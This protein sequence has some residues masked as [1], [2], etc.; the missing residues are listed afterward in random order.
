MRMSERKLEESYIQRG[1]LV[2][3]QFWRVEGDSQAA[4]GVGDI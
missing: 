2:S 1:D 3:G 4:D